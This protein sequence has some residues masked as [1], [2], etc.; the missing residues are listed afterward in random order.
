MMLDV[1]ARI[2]AVRHV[3]ERQIRYLRESIFELFF[4]LLLLTLKSRD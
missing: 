3:V 1:A 2:G 4:D